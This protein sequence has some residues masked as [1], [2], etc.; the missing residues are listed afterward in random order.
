MDEES[1][2]LNHLKRMILPIH[3]MFQTDVSL[4]NILVVDHVLVVHV[5]DVHVVHVLV[6][7]VHVVHVVHAL[8]LVDSTYYQVR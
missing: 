5:L 2:H 8:A 4:Y 7:V 1:N 6:H 3:Y